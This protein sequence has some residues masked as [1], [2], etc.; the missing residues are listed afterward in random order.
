[1]LATNVTRF[2]SSL[3]YLLLY[4]L[5]LPILARQAFNR[6]PTFSGSIFL[7][8]GICWRCPAVKWPRMPY[9][10][11]IDSFT[12]LPYLGFLT[13]KCPTRRKSDLT[14]R[15][16]N[17]QIESKCFV[18]RYSGPTTNNN[19]RH[20][21]CACNNRLCCCSCRSNCFV[22]GYSGNT[23][24]NNT[25]HIRRTCNNRL[26]CRSSGSNCFVFRYSRQHD[27]EQHTPHT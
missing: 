27:E 3:A 7:Y 11:C 20:T 13:K 1:M 17:L 8:R 10:W 18:F 22:I 14:I 23:T 12:C 26:R 5:S 21:H 25:R 24:N 2:D 15:V 16:Q 19:T 6:F 4:L 9:T